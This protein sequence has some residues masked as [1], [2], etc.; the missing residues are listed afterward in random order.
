MKEA[1]KEETASA[2]IVNS[3]HT[4]ITQE[5]IAPPE[6]ELVYPGQQ[7]QEHKPLT[8]PQ[9]IIKSPE[10]TIKS[11]AIE[12]TR[13]QPYLVQIGF[14]FGTSYC[15][16][17]CRDVMID[18][19]WVHLPQKSRKQELPFLIPST[20]VLRNGVIEHAGK[21]NIHYPENGLY[22]LKNALVKTA[23]QDWD[24]PVF[25]PYKQHGGTVE[26]C[27]I[28]ELVETCAVYFLAGA[29]GNIREEIRQRLP[30][31]GELKGDYMAIN[32]AV[33]VADAE[34]PT[35]N[36]LFH[37]ILCEAWSIRVFLFS[38]IY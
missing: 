16:C 15:K 18:K 11:N 14:D 8:L 6:A 30:N 1:L 32:L 2:P 4:P 3:E 37:N 19:A 24:D 29:F 36:E 7:H 20:L 23:L 5:T 33:P 9:E 34:R 35:V 17:I 26:G 12:K 25:A 22:H 28:A 21:H 31:F 38:R 13:R 27:R 10:K